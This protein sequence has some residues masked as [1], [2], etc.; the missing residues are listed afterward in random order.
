MLTISFELGY[1][2]FITDGVEKTFEELQREQYCLT[3]DNFKELLKYAKSIP[4][5]HIS[6]AVEYQVRE[7]YTFTFHST[8]L[9]RKIET[10]KFY[11]K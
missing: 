10:H 5:A 1:I 4:T 11:K 3:F 2:K 8:V 7:I 9:P 6:A